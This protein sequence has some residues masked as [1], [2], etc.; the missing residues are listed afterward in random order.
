MALILKAGK[1]WTD[2]HGTIHNIAVACPFEV[3]GCACKDYEILKV[4][5][6]KDLA[7]RDAGNEPW[8]IFYYRVV[9]VEFDTYFAKAVLNL[10]NVNPYSQSGQWLL[11]CSG[12]FDDWEVS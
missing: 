4:G 5:I 10:L 9:G 3:I 8:K 2:P 7:S 6:W 12:D 11:N 1:T